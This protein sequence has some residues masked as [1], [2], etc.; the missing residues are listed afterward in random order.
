MRLSYSDILY[1]KLENYLVFVSDSTVQKLL[2]STSLI[3]KQEAI[4]Q[5]SYT[6]MESTTVSLDSAESITLI[7]SSQLLEKM[8]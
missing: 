4:L 2:D 7:E 3:Q 1:S 5:T 8:H 6:A